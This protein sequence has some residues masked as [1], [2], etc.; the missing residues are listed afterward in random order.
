MICK[1]NADQP[2]LEWNIRDRDAHPNETYEEFRKRN[3][4]K[5]EDREP[6]HGDE[7]K[8]TKLRAT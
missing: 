3:E 8:F 4:W 6:L 2:E 7:A 5:E 1:Q